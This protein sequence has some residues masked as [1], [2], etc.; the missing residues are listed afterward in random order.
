MMTTEEML[1]KEAVRLKMAK[2]RSKRKPPKLAN[3]HH[4]VKSLPDDNTLSYVSV[5]KW[6]STQESI[7]KTA[8]VTERS[9]KSEVSQKDKD[10]A[11]RTRMGAQ[12]YIRAIKQYIA[13]GDWTSMYYGEFEDKL[14]QWSTVAA[15]GK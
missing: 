8:R 12:S 9:L 13:T 3:V 1:K 5:K 2:L 7:V 11:M 10:Q 6:I 4:T 15:V 14:M